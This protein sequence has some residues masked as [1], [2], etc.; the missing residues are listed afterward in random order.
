MLPIIC[1]IVGL[2]VGCALS[3]YVA[4]LDYRKRQAGVR[5]QAQ[6][7]VSLV[8]VPAILAGLGALI[9]TFIAQI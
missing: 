5:T 6:Y 7:R 3:F 2:V 4:R 9:G 8:V 1:A